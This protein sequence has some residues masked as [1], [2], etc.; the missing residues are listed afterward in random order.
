MRLCKE[1]KKKSSK[2]ITIIYKK[3]KLTK[4][5]IDVVS[6]TVFRMFIE[7]LA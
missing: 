5:I 6:I 3:N 2:Y 4:L 1:N 7:I